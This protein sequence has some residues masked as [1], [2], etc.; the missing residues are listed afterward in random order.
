MKKPTITIWNENV[1]E[2]THALVRD[3]YPQGIHGA[4]AAGLQALDNELTI[5]TATLEQAEH[6]LTDEV[7]NSTDVLIWWGHCAHQQV[8]DAVVE[9]VQTRVLQGMGLVVLHSGH[10]SK[11]FKR[12][13]GTSCALTWREA[14]ERERL[15]VINPGHPI[16]AGI[17][18]CIELEH[19]EMYGEPFGIP[20]PH[21]EIFLSWFEGGEVFRS[22][23]TWLRGNGRIFY[24]RPGHETYPTYHHQHILRVIYNATLWAAPQGHWATVRQAPNIP[25][26]KARET[27]VTQG[28]SVH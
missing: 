28:G 3:I 14:G 1:H 21:E 23:C 26:E 8:D 19:E 9:K 18:T 13:M 6:G 5:R 25:V 20:A 22:G 17:D 16:A 24:F 15:W 4:L 10:F 7:L 2:R 11:I 27:I 12:L